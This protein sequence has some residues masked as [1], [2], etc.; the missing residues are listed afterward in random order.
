MHPQAKDGRPSPEPGN[1]QGG[2]GPAACPPCSP[3]RGSSLT[4]SSDHFS[5]RMTRA[6]QGRPL[7][8]LPDLLRSACLATGTL[9]PGTPTRPRGRRPPPV[10]PSAPG[11]LHAVL[12]SQARD[13]GAVVSELLVAGHAVDVD[14]VDDRVLR[15]DPHLAL[16]RHHHA[17]LSGQGDS[18]AVNGLW[19]PRRAAAPG[20]SQAQVPAGL[21]SHHCHAINTPALMCISV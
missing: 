17:V 6:M 13:A 2:Q 18:S 5:V 12:H 16:L 15:A 7:A 19:V 11:R 9:P 10:K 3:R 20:N 4:T 21:G 1:E 14:D 8:R